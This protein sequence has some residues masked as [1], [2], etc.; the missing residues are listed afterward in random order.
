MVACAGRFGS[1]IGVKVAADA[2]GLKA[3]RMQ[4]VPKRPVDQL[5]PGELG[6]WE[7]AG[8]EPCC[9]EQR[10]QRRVGPCVTVGDEK[11]RRRRPA[12]LPNQ[13]VH[14][15]EAPCRKCQRFGGTLGIARSDIHEGL[16]ARPE[17][18]ERLVAPFDEVQREGGEHD[19]DHR[20]RAL[21]TCPTRAQLGDE[22]AP[23]LRLIEPAVGRTRVAG[24]PFGRGQRVVGRTRRAR[25]RR[26]ET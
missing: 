5:E 2:L 4:G 16:R 7:N 3:E 17:Q 11:A 18:G 6:R 19:S 22:G 10:H 26:H 14:L 15:L 23:G 8:L 9:V 1:R 12:R 25:G 21:R 20:S 24:D 13:R